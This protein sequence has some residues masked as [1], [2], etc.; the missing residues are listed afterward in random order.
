MGFQMGSG[1]EAGV[2]NKGSVEGTKNRVKLEEGTK[3]A[4]AGNQSGNASRKR[5]RK[6]VTESSESCDTESTDS[7]DEVVEEVGLS[8]GQNPGMASS[9]RYPRRSSRQKQQVSYNYKDDVSD[10]DDDD[11][12]IEANSKKSRGN[13]SSGGVDNEN[14]K[15][16][17]KEDADIINGS[18]N[19]TAV[20]EDKKED[21]KEGCVPLEENLPN[22]KEQTREYKENGKEQSGIDKKVDGSKPKSN[23]KLH[24]EILSYPEPEFYDFDQDRKESRFSPE[25]IW[26]AYDDAGGM[27]RYYVRIR[28]V[29]PGFKLQ[30]TWLEFNPNPKDQHE[31]DWY[32]ENLPAATGTFKHGKT[33]TITDHAIFSHMIYFEKGK[34]RGSYKIYPV[35]GQ[36]W[37]L[38][39][40]W[41]IKWSSDPDIHRHYE[42]DYVE[43]ISDYAEGLGIRV[44]YLV[45]VEGFKFL[46]RRMENKEM[47]IPSNELMRFSHMVPSYRMTGDERE[48]IPGGSF[49]LDPASLPSDNEESP[50]SERFNDVKAYFETVD[51]QSNGCCSRSAAE[52]KPATGSV[53]PET[54]KKS[55]EL[56]EKKIQGKENLPNINGNQEKK[57]G[58]SD[59]TKSRATE[60]DDILGDGVSSPNNAFEHS[61]SSPADSPKAAVYEYPD[62]EFY[63]FD[64]DRSKDK[65]EPGQLWALYNDID[66]MPTFYARI[67]KVERVDFKVHITWLES[68]PMIEEEIKWSEVELPIGCGTFKASSDS[69][70]YDTTET[71]SHQ[72]R[73]QPTWK[74]N[75]YEIY[76]RKGEVWAVYK[77][78]SIEL[79][80]DDLENCEYEM[81]EVFSESSFEMTVLVLKKVEGH[82]TVFEVQRKGGEAFTMSIPRNEWLRFAH[83]IPA[84]RLTE[85]KGGKLRGCLELD[86][87]STP[88]ILF[89]TSSD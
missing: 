26:A 85:E 29:S 67:K 31:I 23:S 73:V 71:F 77:N 44:N 37:A 68:C 8:T 69:Q 21:G 20:F 51:A 19:G 45:K 82:K 10:D 75:R 47:Q 53:M 4:Q 80:R 88:A 83:K 74:K 41:D 40:D 54:I 50:F 35:K 72:I 38:F 46:F 32:N 76:P 9:H 64:A 60:K 1:S 43:V 48:S 52:K 84:F 49:E 13:G 87:A 89:C 65:F 28:T 16:C 78:W 27:P 12:V 18:A 55:K 11:F 66:G 62:P 33:E 34:S 79:A 42:F 25:Q 70:I 36:I 56:N 86:P 22:G 39:K 63:N 2:G 6:V 59:S 30:I 17:S 14:S 7:E 24:S 58:V 5:G 15:P 61:D 3:R 57:P 81:V